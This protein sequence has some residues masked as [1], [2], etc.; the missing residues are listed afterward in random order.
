MRPA[1][2]ARGARVLAVWVSRVFHPFVV[3]VLVL[4]LA[5]HLSGVP[6]SAALGWTALAVAALILP[7]LA[8]VLL[9][10]RA[11]RYEDVDVSVREDRHLLY[12]LAGACFLLL[13]V[14]LI[15]F[16]APW[17]V[18]E[19]LRAA[20]FAFG[21]A[22]VLNQTVGKVSLHMLAMG[23][24]A[25]VLAFASAPLAVVLGLLGL[26]VGWSRLYLTRHTALEVVLGWG[27]GLLCFASWLLAGRA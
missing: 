12:G 14:L 23:G 22:A 25:A 3:P 4:F 13:I 21:V 17:V 16:D 10:I 8:F 6:P 15:V 7:V 27:V 9:R 11:G 20:L 5:Q 24:C 18:Q 2:E 19:T 1:G 26:L